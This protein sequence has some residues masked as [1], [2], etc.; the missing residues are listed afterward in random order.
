MI[1]CNSVFP[2]QG[3]QPSFI[4]SELLEI[5]SDADIDALISNIPWQGLYPY[6]HLPDF[7]PI[8]ILRI[9][10]NLYNSHRSINIKL[11]E[12]NKLNS[13]SSK[14]LLLLDE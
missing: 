13:I 7:I 10:T 12:D 14:L 6:L 9:L 2:F 5:R 11:T 4:G 1:Q 3:R 8:Y